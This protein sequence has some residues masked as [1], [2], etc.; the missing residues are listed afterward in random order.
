MKA[1]K[2]IVGYPACG[3]G[4]FRL[5]LTTTSLRITVAAEAFAA[6]VARSDFMANCTGDEDAVEGLFLP[7]VADAVVAMGLVWDLRAPAEGIAPHW[8]RRAGEAATAGLP[9]PQ[10]RP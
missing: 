10:L 8:L 4:G 9:D 1:M 7:R 3:T 6:V 2:T 5:A